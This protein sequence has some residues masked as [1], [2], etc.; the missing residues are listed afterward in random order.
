M[1]DDTGVV[2]G[3]ITASDI[4]GD[5]PIRLAQTTG[6]DHSEIMVDMIITPQKDIMVLEWS[7]IKD[8]KIGHIAATMH[9]LECC[10]LPVIENGRI[11]G[12]FSAR[13][14]SW[15]LGHDVSENTLCAHSLAEI[16]QTLS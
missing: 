16:V 15:H 5:V 10:H 7:H 3:Q 9:S 8:A 11:R 1:I 13:N 12:L 14:I 4:P 6:K 2:I